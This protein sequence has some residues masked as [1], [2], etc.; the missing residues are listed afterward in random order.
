MSS[1][2][3]SQARGEHTDRL[4]P[5]DCDSEQPAEEQG[6][7]LGLDRARPSHLY[8]PCSCSPLRCS[9]LA[10]V[11]HQS[12][13]LGLYFLVEMTSSRW[14]FHGPQHFTSLPP[15]AVLQPRGGSTTLPEALKTQTPPC[16][17]TMFT[18]Y[19][20]VVADMMCHYFLHYTLVLHFFN[21]HALLQMTCK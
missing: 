5:L 15:T 17:D 3:S 2:P 12:P 21:R 1:F 8:T 13:R 9:A 6:S 10:P 19:R 14:F 11:P 16:P 4:C 18:R 20:S 7:L